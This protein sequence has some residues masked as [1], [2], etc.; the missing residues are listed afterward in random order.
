MKPMCRL[1]D[2]RRTAMTDVRHAM[3][4]TI[5]SPKGQS[6]QPQRAAR[7][8]A[9]GSLGQCRDVMSQPPPLVSEPGNKGFGA[10]RSVGHPL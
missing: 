10:R 9:S 4:A 7:P 8:P 3:V 5:T 1:A 2:P 6:D